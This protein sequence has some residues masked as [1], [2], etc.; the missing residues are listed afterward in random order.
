MRVEQAIVRMK[1]RIEVVTRLR[2][3]IMEYPDETLSVIRSWLRGAGTS[4]QERELRARVTYA[5]A[6]GKAG[7]DG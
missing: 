1:R 2:A 7:A 6:D 4:E 5:N 3:L